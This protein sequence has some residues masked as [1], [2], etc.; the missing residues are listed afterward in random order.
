[1]L[2]KIIERIAQGG[3]WS[4]EDLAS[5]LG[6]THELMTAMLEDLERRGYLKPAGAGCSRAC[7][8]CT[9]SAGCIKGA[10]DRVWIVNLA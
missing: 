6:T 9:M 5:E 2:R 3:S 1:M 10:F 4:V 8:S 7:A